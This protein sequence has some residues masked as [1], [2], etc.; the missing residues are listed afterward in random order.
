MVNKIKFIKVDGVA[1]DKNTV[2]DGSYPI[3]SN[4]YALYRADTSENSTVRTFVDWIL[5]DYGQKAVKS[6]GFVPLTNVDADET[7]NITLALETKGT[8]Q[9]KPD[10]YKISTSYYSINMYDYLKYEYA[11]DNYTKNLYIE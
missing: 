4:I 9:G 5:C 7:P 6:A 3:L 1:P 2:Y 8:G 11:S 10:D